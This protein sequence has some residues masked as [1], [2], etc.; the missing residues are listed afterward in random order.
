MNAYLFDNHRELMLEQ[1]PL[2][3]SDQFGSI[4]LR[5]LSSSSS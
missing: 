1:F 4:W 5:K 2:C 3:C